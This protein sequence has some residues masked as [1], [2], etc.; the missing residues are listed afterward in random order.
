[1]DPHHSVTNAKQHP[2]DKGISKGTIF[3]P[4][5]SCGP[6][7]SF[8]RKDRQGGWCQRRGVVVTVPIWE[9]LAH[10]SAGVRAFVNSGY[11][12]LY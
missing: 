3:T 7:L 2:L 1:M 9:T 12:R 6:H 10:H 4:S 5:K 8:T 11:I